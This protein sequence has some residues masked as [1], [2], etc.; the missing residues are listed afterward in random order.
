MMV[1][2]EMG[3]LKAGSAYQALDFSYPDDKLV[4]MVLDADVMA[5]VII[6]FQRNTFF[7]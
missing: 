1:V 3:V 7:L 2:A 4:F 5:L 6:G